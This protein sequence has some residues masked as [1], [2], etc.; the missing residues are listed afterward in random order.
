MAMS[1][2]KLVD[3]ATIHAGSLGVGSLLAGTY[4]IVG[5]LGSGGMNVVYDAIDRG[6]ERR[7]AIKVPLLAA[8]N[9]AL[10][11]EARAIAAIA[12]PRFPIIHT[13]LEEGGE[14]RVVMERLVGSTLE[15]H[16]D[17]FRREGSHMAIEEA[18]DWLIEIA[19]GLS[20]AHTAG[21]S[22]RDLKP[23][24]VL[25][26]GGRVVLFDLGL[27]V[28][29]VLVEGESEAAGSVRYMAP[30]VILGDVHRGGG[31]L[32]DLYAL[33]NIAFELLTGH[34][35]FIGDSAENVLANHVC[36]D[37]PDVRALRK[38]VPRELAAL[39]TELLSKRP[40]ARPASAESVVWQLEA[41]IPS[42]LPSSR[43]KVLVVDDE[44]HVGNAL[45]RALEST[46]PRLTVETTTFPED[47]VGA[48]S[49][50][51]PDIVLVDLNMPK[52]NG[53]E[54]CMSLMSRPARRRPH[55]VA[56]SS[57][58]EPRDVAV[59]AALG[60]NDFVSKGEDFLPRMSSVIGRLHE[61]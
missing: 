29:E 52:S 1:D 2:P 41:L 46:F 21:V 14:V 3:A 39:V 55:V 15:S 26:S 19:K 12:S 59:L 6:L 22:H 49:E 10:V 56:M 36:A 18:L 17:D 30:E 44:P 32:V 37:V 8:Y 38:D 53:I 23:S 61:R 27:A 51:M 7:V 50:S 47:I 31:P 57:Q 43:S 4:E 25:R 35:P 13:I 40:E 60:V 24:N 9:E 33:G 28:P 54:V 34:T 48:S 45:R 11:R 42:S 58:A 20:A 16:L 5:V